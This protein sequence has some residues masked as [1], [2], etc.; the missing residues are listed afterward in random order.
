MFTASRLV[1]KLWLFNADARN[2]ATVERSL[3]FKPSNIGWNP[4][5]AA[6]PSKTSRFDTYSTWIPEPNQLLGLGGGFKYCGPTAGLLRLDKSVVSNILY[7]HPDRGNDPIWLM[8]DIFQKCWNHQ[9]DSICP[10]KYHNPPEW[11]GSSA[12]TFL[13][14]KFVF[15][16]FDSQFATTTT[17]SKTNTS[18]VC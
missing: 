17:F 11:W 5:Y 12:V 1:N 14:S 13:R 4:T 6:M 16:H 18:K 2:W 15:D 7:F 3:F 10:V 9:L 8:T